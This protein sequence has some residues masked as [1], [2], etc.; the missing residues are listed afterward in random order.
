MKFKSNIELQAGLEDNN[1]APGTSGQ[2]LS[3]TG[4]GVEWIDTS[5]IS[6]GESE[7]VHIACKNTSG[8]AISKGDPVYIT[9][10]VGASLRIQIAKAD[11]SDPAKMPA[12]GL[13]ETDLGLNAEGFVIVSGILKNLTTNPLSTSDGTPSSNDT[14]YVKAGGGLTRIKPTGSGNLIQNVGKVGRVS[15]ANS[16]SLAVST[17]MRTNDIPN[18]NTGKIWVGSPTYTTE[19][20]VVHLDESNGRIGIGTASPSSKLQ[21][22]GGVQMSDDTDAASSSKVGTLRYRADANNSYVDMCM[23]TG[24]STYE[25]INIA[26]NNW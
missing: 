6:V 21:V 16:G 25:W 4:T 12:V 7:Q 26:Q 8:V 14:V 9:G 13:V 15:S 23:Q 10:T 18:L 5:T 22:D 2:V 17:I 11:A 3:S 1:A 24:V 20:T 19:S